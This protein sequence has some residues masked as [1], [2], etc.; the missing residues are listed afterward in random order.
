M[1]DAVKICSYLLSDLSL[2]VQVKR[3]ILQQK[4]LKRNVATAA[5]AFHAP[6]AKRSHRPHLLID[7]TA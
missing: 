5:A 6:P 3:F 2:E 7:R 1:I 4:S